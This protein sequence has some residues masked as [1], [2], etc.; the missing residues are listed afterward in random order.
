MASLKMQ[1]SVKGRAC[2]QS[3]KLSIIRFTRSFAQYNVTNAIKDE[4]VNL[5]PCHQAKGA[6]SILEFTPQQA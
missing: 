6:F 1:F 4:M 2:G 5:K 3:L